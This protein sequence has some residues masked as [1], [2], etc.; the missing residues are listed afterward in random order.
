M[1]IARFEDLQCWQKSQQLGVFIYKTFGQL[2]DFSFRDQICRASVSVSNNLAEG[3]DRGS[4]KE[5]LRF[6]YISRGSNS[7]VKSMLYLAKSLEFINEIQFNEGIG[8]CNEN[9]K[10]INGFISYLI[11]NTV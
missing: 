6:I 4:N 10:L 9:G 2:K 7:E 11:K 8:L 1:R 5:F 3:F